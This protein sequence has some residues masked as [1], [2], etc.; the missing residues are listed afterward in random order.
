MQV[1]IRTKI[2]GIIAAFSVGFAAFLIATWATTTERLEDSDYQAVVAMKDFVADIAPP[3]LYVIEAYT[4]G[5]EVA[6]FHQADKLAEVQGRL[7]SLRTGFDARRMLWSTNLGRSSIADILAGDN[8]RT[9]IQV[10]AIIDDEVIPAVTRGDAAAETLAVGRLHEAY[11]AHRGVIDTLM[12]KA[13][14]E[15]RDRIESAAQGIYRRKLTLTIAG[16][17]MLIVISITGYV[18]ASRISRRLAATAAVLDKVA[19]GDFSSRTIEDQDDEI[20]RMVAS[21][22]R[23]VESVDEVFQQVRQVAS[24]M[25]SASSSL[26]ST[27]EAI[28]TGAQQQAASIEETAASL[29]EITATVKQSAGNAQQASQLATGSREVAERGGEVVAQAVI[30]M[31]EVKTSSRK[32]GDIITTIDEIALQ[33]NLLALNAAVEAARAGEQGRGF[34]VVAAEV[35]NL[36]QRSATAAKE[37]K[38]LIQEALQ[39]V[40][41]GHQL[42]G[43]SGQSLHEIIGSVKKVTDIF[44][45]IAAA[46]REQ[47]AGVDQVNEAVSQMD[48]VTQANSNQTT[49]LSRTAERLAGQARQL[50]DMLA[51]FTLSSDRARRRHAGGK[52]VARRGAR[53]EARVEARAERQPVARGTGSGRAAAFGQGKDSDAEPDEDGDVDHA[54]ASGN[55]SRAPVRADRDGGDDDDRY[56]VV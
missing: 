37:V 31:N 36:A 4:L 3:P 28:A 7:T 15:T 23:A 43:E 34:A 53:I 16:L 47:S 2:L 11:E 45:E 27:S 56:E 19:D 26:A 38:A 48:R 30:A 50:D 40:A 55:S 5:L 52:R 35:G 20:G 14:V 8:S 44:G 29:E 25:T 54:L 24:Q 12:A 6:A 39:R 49:E 18:V 17:L 21:L 33:T 42:V 1:T 10:F 32:I 22:N 41:V 46:A 13:D 51:G 9:A